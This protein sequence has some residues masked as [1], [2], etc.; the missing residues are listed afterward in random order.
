MRILDWIIRIL[1]LILLLGIL[2]G[3]S[4]LAIDQVHLKVQ[5]R[6]DSYFDQKFAQARVEIENYLGSEIQRVEKKI[7]ASQKEIEAGLL[8]EIQRA[9]KKIEASQK[10]IEAGLL[11][12]FSLILVELDQI[13]NGLELLNQKIENLE[14]DHQNL[15]GEL[16]ELKFELLK[17][18]KKIEKIRIFLNF[19]WVE[20]DIR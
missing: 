1:A 17:L 3:G 6:I 10:E 9:E 7:E 18:E 2:V 5:S 19:H 20:I 8:S 13:Q 4:Y 12:D 14:K 15:E 11:K 16:K